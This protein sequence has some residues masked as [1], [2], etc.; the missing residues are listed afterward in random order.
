MMDCAN[1]LATGGNFYALNS[2]SDEEWQEARACIEKQDIK[3]S[4][5][6]PTA[7]R[8]ARPERVK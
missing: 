1:A 5:T 3:H 4:S 8:L 6:V 2:W 7:N